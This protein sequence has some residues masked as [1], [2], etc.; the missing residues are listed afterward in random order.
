M[1]RY[2][3]IILMA[4][5][6]AL[7]SAQGLQVGFKGLGDQA[8]EPLEI[9]ADSMTINNETGDAELRGNVVVEQG[10]LRLEAPLVDVKYSQDG[11]VST[12]FASGGVLL[13]TP[14]EE[15]EAQQATYAMD[16]ETMALRGDVLMVQGRSAVSAEEMDIDLKTDLAVFNGRV[17]TILY[18]D[19][20]D[21]G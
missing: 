19:D 15:V 18:N 6:P 13:V 4:V 2:V 16:K 20:S 12:I 3:L 7:V 10:D 17:R 9:A 8:D 21:G 1:Q 11:G 5:L 14:E